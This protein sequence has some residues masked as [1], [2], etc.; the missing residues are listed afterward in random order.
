MPDDDPSS[1]TPSS[2]PGQNAS[3]QS[4][5]PA[6]QRWNFFSIPAPVKRVF[7]EFPLLT[8]DANELPLRA[9]KSRERHVLH[10][11]TTDEDAKDGKPSFNPAC[12]KWQVWR[13]YNINAPG[14]VEEHGADV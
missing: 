13:E 1:A 8:Y 4:A 6:A 12:L 11:F 2:R 14:T 5:K 10:I 3:A 7:D 9:P